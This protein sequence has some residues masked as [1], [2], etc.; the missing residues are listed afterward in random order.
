MKGTNGGGNGRRDLRT[1]PIGI[2]DS[3][4]AMARSDA[5]LL[6]SLLIPLSISFFA[7]FFVYRHTARNR[8]IQAMI[9]VLL[10]ALLMPVAYE[11]AWAIFPARFYI[12]STYEVRHAR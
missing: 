2:F 4:G 5:R 11:A 1:C 12:A 3:A 10:S 6:G 7:G 8:K 9:T